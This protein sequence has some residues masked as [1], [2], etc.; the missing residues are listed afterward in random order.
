MAFGSMAGAIQ[1]ES[2]TGSATEA[3][4]PYTARAG[5]QTAPRTRPSGQR[6]TSRRVEMQIFVKSLTG[7]TVTLDVD[8]SYSVDYVMAVIRLV[9][10]IPA[11]EQRLTFAGKQLESGRTLSEYNIQQNCTAV[12]GILDRLDAS[13]L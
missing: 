7:K 4:H 11:E 2:G 6:G 12:E 1:H 5:M 3:R 8:G 9:E 13:G 10:G